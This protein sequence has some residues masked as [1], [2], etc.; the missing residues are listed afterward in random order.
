[1]VKKILIF[2]I[3]F[4][5]FVGFSQEDTSV[6]DL[7]KM[8]PKLWTGC[9][10]I[11]VTNTKDFFIPLSSDYNAVRYFEEAVSS[12][13]SKGKFLVG[14]VSLND[15]TKFVTDVWVE[16]TDGDNQIILR[17]CEINQA[18]NEG[19]LFSEYEKA[20]DFLNDYYTKM[21]YEK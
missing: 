2:V 21:G 3:S 4:V 20:F 11:V 5:S 6:I 1:M 9:T 13:F 14:V 15:K 10:D 7:S 8:F 16:V 18:Y 12:T 19:V 17:L